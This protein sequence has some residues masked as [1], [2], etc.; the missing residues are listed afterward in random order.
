MGEGRL[1]GDESPSNRRLT[2]PEAAAALGIT[3]GAVRGRVKRRTLR[4]V[5]EGG[6]VYVLLEGVSS[7]TKHDEPTGPAADQSEL[8]EVLREQLQAE[9]QAH[10]EAR[11]IIAGLVERIPQ[12]EAP[13]EASESPETVEEVSDRAEPR[14]AAEARDDLGVER[15]RREMAESTLREGMAEERRRREEAERERDDLRQE[16]HVLRRP[17][18]DAETVEEAPDRAEPRSDV[19]GAEQPVQRRSWL[20]RMFGS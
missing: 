16:L 19:P 1:A 15:A 5:R 10:A 7:S 8:V 18:E 13:Q 6:T 4:S 17:P 3:E 9:R 11:R 20:R 14:S 12:L 2:V